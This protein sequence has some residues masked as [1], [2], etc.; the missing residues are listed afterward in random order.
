MHHL[1]PAPTVARA[2][3]PA[4]PEFHGGIEHGRDV[5][6]GAENR[7]LPRLDGFEHEGGALTGSEGDAR[8]YVTVDDLE[9]A[10]RREAELQHGRA[11]ARTLRHKR[12]LVA[13]ARVV[14]AGRDLDHEP[15][16]SAHGEHTP[17]HPRAVR[18]LAGT[19]R[20]HEVLHLAHPV[21]HQK[22]GDEDVGVGEVELL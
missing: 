1:A 16:F 7:H 15:H 20:G 22:P 17:D 14:E 3:E 11:E 9:R 12:N 10:A 4:P 8:A 13:G 21:G 19:C 18:R 2:A 5:D 6:I